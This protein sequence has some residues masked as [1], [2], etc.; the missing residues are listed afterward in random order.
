MLKVDC[1]PTRLQ[2]AKVR[3]L[4]DRLPLDTKMCSGGGSDAQNNNNKVLLTIICL[5]MR[6][7]VP[8]PRGSVFDY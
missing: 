3:E 5:L 8:V 1:D 4:L 6:Q 7:S 2:V